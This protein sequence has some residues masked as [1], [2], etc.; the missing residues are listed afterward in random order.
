MKKFAAA[1]LFFMLIF[2]C[3]GDLSAQLAVSMRITQLNYLP[4]EPIFVRVAIRN[5]SAHAVAFGKTDKLKGGLRFEIEPDSDRSKRMVQ[6]LNPDNLPPLIGSIIPPGATQ[7]YTFNLCD[8]YDMRTVG[9]YCIRAVVSHGLFRDEYLSNPTYVSVV[10]GVTLWKMP[11]GVPDLTN[12]KAENKKV[13]QRQYSLISYSTGKAQVLNLKI[14]DENN[15]Y[16]NRRVAFD[17]GP[18]FKPQLQV[19]FLSRLHMIVA[20]SNRVYAYYV[21]TL[22]G[23][24]DQR[25]ILIKVAGVPMLVSD[26]KNGYVTVAGGRE[27]V[28]DQDYEEIR[29]LP[30]LGVKGSG[31]AGRL[32]MKDRTKSLDAVQE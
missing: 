15:V 26:P 6:P 4:F 20:A 5:F 24:L 12:N 29:D 30:F 18:E 23:K 21:F 17:L 28:P 27:A 1:I 8:Y 32:P 22:D 11:V 25:K 9:K 10:R 3:I 2:S 14:E 7:E 13:E 31:A 19:D 16:A